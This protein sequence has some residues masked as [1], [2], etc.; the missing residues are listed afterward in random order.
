MTKC[1]TPKHINA[2]EGRKI[3]MLKWDD[4]MTTGIRKIDAQ[5]REIINKYNQFLALLSNGIDKQENRE[6]A[7]NL[8][9][10]LQFFTAWHFARE[11]VCFDHYNCSAAKANKYAHAEFLRIFN[12]FYQQWHIDGMDIEQAKRSYQELVNWM[13]NHIAHMDTQVYPFVK[14]EH[15]SEN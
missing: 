14:V 1:V 12:D 15:I 11:E 5:H 3:T 4:S 7:N 6:E 9:D 2:I 8:L 10:Y 13:A